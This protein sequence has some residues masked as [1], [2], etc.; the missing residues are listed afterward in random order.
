MG[1]PVHEFLHG[2][3]L[4]FS[5]QKKWKSIQFGVIWESFTPYCYC[6]EAISLGK[7]YLG[8]L[9]PC[10]VLGILTA[11]IG[12]VFGSVFW[13]IVGLSNILFAGGDL[14]IAC[15]L[16]RYLRNKSEKKIL[17]HP[18]ECGCTAFLKS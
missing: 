5:C 3:G 12:A 10:T 14:T 11:L 8:L 15:I 17:D 7:Y 16:F 6:G 9:M 2:F 13:L 18:S 4:H 1:I